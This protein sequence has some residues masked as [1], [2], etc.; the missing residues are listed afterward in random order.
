MEISPEKS[1]TMA[2]LGQDP[3]IRTHHNIYY[4]ITRYRIHYKIKM[5]FKRLA[6]RTQIK[7]NDNRRKNVKYKQ[8]N[9]FYVFKLFNC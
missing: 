5:Y 4:K 2:F 3:V 7:F 8:T 1:E 9:N 6:Q